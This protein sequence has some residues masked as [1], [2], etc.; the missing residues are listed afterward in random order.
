[1]AGAVHSSNCA[2]RVVNEHHARHAAHHTVQQPLSDAAAAVACA[3]F[4]MLG[5]STPPDTPDENVSPARL[6]NHFC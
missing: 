3:R 2:V 4:A 5:P 1:M 6:K